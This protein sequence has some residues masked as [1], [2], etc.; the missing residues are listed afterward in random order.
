[1]Q[2]FWSLEGFEVVT[3]LLLLDSKRL[4]NTAIMDMMR[5]M[6]HLQFAHQPMRHQDWCSPYKEVQDTQSCFGFY[7]RL[8]EEEVQE[9]VRE[10]LLSEAVDHNNT[11]PP[12]LKVSN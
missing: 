6:M 7:N 2:S 4:D 10:W 3:D 1:M 12:S 8:T 5:G 11:K 9:I